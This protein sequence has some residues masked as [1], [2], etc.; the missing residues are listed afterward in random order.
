MGNFPVY[1]GHN[2][3]EKI[4]KSWWLINKNCPMGDLEFMMDIHLN[5]G[6]GST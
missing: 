5:E 2:S 1:K 4:K 3:N 6:Q